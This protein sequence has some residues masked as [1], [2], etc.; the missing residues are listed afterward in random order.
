MAAGGIAGCLW[1]V[2]D[3]DRLVDQ[4]GYLEGPLQTAMAV[5]LVL[6]TL[7]MGRRAV[8]WILP[9]VVLLAIAYG[10][11]GDLLPGRFGHPGFPLPSFLGTLTRS[12][13]QTSELQPLM[14][15]SYSDFCLNKKKTSTI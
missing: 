14:R 11:F 13:E 12:E 1:V 10:V 6:V 4:Y 5:G 15:I 9:A 3:R 7:D 8:K 2:L